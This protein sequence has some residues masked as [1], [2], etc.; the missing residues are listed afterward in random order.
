LL[1][2]K[3]NFWHKCQGKEEEPGNTDA[4]EGGWGELTLTQ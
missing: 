2:K 3:R 1:R 4:D